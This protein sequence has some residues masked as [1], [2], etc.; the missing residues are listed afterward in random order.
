MPARPRK[1]K[2]NSKAEVGVQIVTR[3]ILA[4]LCHEVFHSLTQLNQ[5]IGE[6]LVRL[7]QKPF[8][9]IPGSR[10]SLFAELDAPA[11]KPLPAYPLSI[12]LRQTTRDT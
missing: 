11:L 12:H 2:D 6:V 10:A 4:M 7:N 8:Q 5:R 9:K 1:P 3:W